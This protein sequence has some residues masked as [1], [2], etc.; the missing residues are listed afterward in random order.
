M[1]EPDKRECC[2]R[3]EDRAGGADGGDFEF[4]SGPSA[5]RVVGE[6]RGPYARLLAQELRG[7]YEVSEVL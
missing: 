1:D 7:D 3:S 6:C 2:R 4:G 5:V